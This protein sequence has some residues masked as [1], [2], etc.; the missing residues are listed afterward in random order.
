[1]TEPSGIIKNDSWCVV[2]IV[3]AVWK[4]T[5]S[6]CNQYLPYQT[7]STIYSFMVPFNK[8]HQWFFV[9]AACKTSYARGLKQMQLATDYS[10]HNQSVSISGPF[11]DLTQA[12]TT[13]K[14]WKAK[15][16]NTNLPRT[17]RFQNGSFAI[18]FAVF[19]KENVRY[20]V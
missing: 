13:Q 4:R 3:V 18:H 14:A 6:S 19:F 2:Y 5:H 12:C 16:T 11:L 7:A 17:V 9:L 1:M 10:L 20:S 8:K 15:L